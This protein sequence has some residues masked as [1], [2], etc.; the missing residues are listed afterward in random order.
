MSNQS[1]KKQTHTVMIVWTSEALVIF[2]AALLAAY[3]R[4]YFTKISIVVYDPFLVKTLVLTIIYIIVLHAMRLYMPDMYRPDRTMLIRLVQAT[5][6]ST[7]ALLIVFYVVP[8]LKAWRGIL[9]FHTILLPCAILLWRLVVTRVFKI[10]L[11]RKNVLIIGSGRLAKKIGEEICGDSSLGLRLAGFIDDNPDKLGLSLVN[12]G[13]IG[14][15]GDI[16]RLSNAE[17]IDTII[18]ALPDKRAKLPMSAL[19]DCK[20]QGIHVEEGETF[21][22]RVTGKIP[23]DHLKPSWMVFSDGFKSLRSR[24][25]LK[26]VLDLF[27]AFLMLTAALPLMVVTAIIIKL[28]SK[29]PIIFKQVR[30][31]ENGGN[32]DIYKFRSMRQDAE[33][34]TGPVWAGASDARTTLIGRLIRLTRIDELPQI[35]NVI[36]GDMS[37]VGPRPERPFFVLKLREVIPYYEMRTVV[38]PGITGWAQI[39]YPYGA[40]VQDALEKLQYDIYY[41]KNMSPLLD[42]MIFVMTVRVVLTG[43]GAR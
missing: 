29:G 21:N 14:G 3:L 10:E 26:R 43:K 41:I 16:N 11:P 39:K 31:G 23:L 38:K 5:A 34:G 32:F 36:K 37:F 13:V 25:I 35:V 8:S 40:N 7:I 19:L 20:L 27:M 42:F 4:F 18:V 28:T 15:Y 22:E 2:L 17:H 30:V 9:L 33:A 6:I 12:P 1:G 24:K